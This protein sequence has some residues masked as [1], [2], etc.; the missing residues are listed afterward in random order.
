[1][2][3][4]SLS[5]ALTS[6]DWIFMACKELC[7]RLGK[8]LSEAVSSGEE[9]GC[10]LT[11]FKNGELIV[12]IAAGKGVDTESLFPVFSVGK[13]IM[14]TAFHR[15]VEKGVIGYDSRVA[16]VWPEYGRNGKEDTRVWH[17]MSHRAGLFKVPA[18]TADDDMSKWDLMCERLAAAR[19]ECEPGTKC[20][21]HGLTYAWLLGETARRA[22]G[23]D[24][25]RIVTDEVLKPLGIQ[26][27]FFFGTT[28]DADRRFVKVDISG[29]TVKQDWRADFIH[30][31]RVRHGFIPS[32]N[33]VANA[34]SIAKHYASLIGEVDGVRL[35]RPETVASA[36]TLRRAADD[37]IPPGGWAKFGLGYAL[38]GPDSDMGSMFG[39]G[40]AAG[41]EGFADRKSGLAVGFT[42][43]KPGPGH[44]VHPVRD[45]ISAA[46]GL[47]IRH[48]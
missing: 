6:K 18:D 14:T 36:A 28:A 9:S 11:V 13:G 38:C 4:F 45:R 21:Y 29:L 26:D 39:H 5:A 15:L 10:Q 32:A 34:F 16:D 43:N 19:P 31:D 40:G 17:V 24:F 47:K 25:H 33:G 1:M 7:G 22:G 37:P 44:P 42:K 23:R 12:N 8:I 20:F 41:S 27:S 46:L 3:S 2:Y 35:L 30:N 48:W